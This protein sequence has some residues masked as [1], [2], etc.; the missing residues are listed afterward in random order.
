MEPALTIVVLTAAATSLTL[1]ADLV[2]A[3][4]SWLMA[5]DPSLPDPIRRGLAVI[6]LGTACLAIARPS[7]ATAAT[8]PP[9]VRI[10]G[11][12]SHG[13]PADA[14]TPSTAET[15]PAPDAYVVERGD[16][17]WRIASRILSAAGRA[18]RGTD[19]A[20]LWRAIYEANREVIG[21]DP[22][23][24]HPGQVLTLPQA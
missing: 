2:R 6:V 21:D 3:S 5:R 23:L 11:L 8:V 18:T 22:N 20:G 12:I 7:F 15:P 13:P 1:V 14:G 9:S 19:V 24:I 16:C 4:A 17:L 10:S